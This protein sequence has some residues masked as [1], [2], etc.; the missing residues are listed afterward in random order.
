MF[1]AIL[2]MIVLNWKQ[3]KCLSASEWMYKLRHS[4]VMEYY[5]ARKKEQATDTL[6]KWIHFTEVTLGENQTLKILNP[7]MW[8]SRTDET[9]LQLWKSNHLLPGVSMEEILLQRDMREP[10]REIGMYYIVIMM[11]AKQGC[12]LVK[13]I[14]LYTWNVW[15]YCTCIV[16][17]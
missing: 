1:I 12:T 10:S 8:K 2:F 14:S 6:C 17:Q 9:N 4:H 15:I 7:F 11:V 13:L 3:P 16:P 5:S